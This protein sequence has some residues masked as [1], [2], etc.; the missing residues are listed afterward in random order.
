VPDVAN[1][2]AKAGAQNAQPSA[3][4]VELF[5]MGINALPSWAACLSMRRQSV[6]TLEQKKPD[7]KLCAIP[8]RPRCT[9]ARPCVDEVRIDLARKLHLSPDSG[10]L[11][12]IGA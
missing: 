5:G 8:G 11:Q 1:E 6:N 4:P 9:A 7:Q 3:A 10:G 2:R 12:D